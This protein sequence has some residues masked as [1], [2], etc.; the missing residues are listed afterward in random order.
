M[1][2]LYNLLAFA[3]PVW[4]TSSFPIIRKILLILTAIC[5]VALIVVVMMQE[6]SSSGGT[7]ALSGEVESYYA[8]N[9]GRNKE[10]RLKLLT[11][12]LASCVAG[13]TVLYFILTAIYAGV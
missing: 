11:I 9:K 8:Q 4:V 2:K 6:S 1:Q 13:F 10:G 5:A 12:I 3:S 7:N